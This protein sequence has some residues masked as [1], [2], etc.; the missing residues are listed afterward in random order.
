MA[1][2]I[3]IVNFKTY[4]QA[5][6]E[7]AVALAKICQT[8]GRK[9]KVDIRIAV[10]T[11]D[12]SAVAKAVSIPVYAQHADFAM[13]G[14]STGWVTA[15]A[16]K[17]AGAKGTLL[18]HA[19]HR[20]SIQGIRGIIPHLRKSRLDVIA[21]AADVRQLQEFERHVD[22]DLFCIEPPELIGGDV[23]VA[24]ARPGVI[25]D[26]VRASS[27]PLLVGAGIKNRTDLTIA[28][29]LG[30]AGVLLSSHIVLAHDQ[31]GALERLI[32]PRR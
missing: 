19:E 23:S 29:S 2:P 1:K 25:G 16:L 10:Q 22:A 26:A 21:I 14:K 7:R 4:P 15:H 27:R 8:L 32:A 11:T 13:P 5:T 31:R 3:V 12:I 28:L 6:G 18:N 9:H 30:A 20:I 24:M 17:K